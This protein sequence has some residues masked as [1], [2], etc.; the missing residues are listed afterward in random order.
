MVDA[1][2]LCPGGKATEYS[3]CWMSL[4]DVDFAAIGW[5]YVSGEWLS[6]SNLRLGMLG[7]NEA[8]LLS[9]V[10]VV[11]FSFNEF[12]ERMLVLALLKIP[13]PEVSDLNL[14]RNFSTDRNGCCPCAFCCP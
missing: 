3:I 14:R 7:D 9:I 5:S 8:V 4:G 12:V 2:G 10:C 1:R 11:G 6:G 13:T